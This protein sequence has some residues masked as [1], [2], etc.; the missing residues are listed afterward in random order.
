MHLPLS[1]PHTRDGPGVE[2]GDR[3]TLEATGCSK[4]EEETWTNLL[5]RADKS[6]LTW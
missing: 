4:V 5:L 1:I 6:G 3:F 2:R